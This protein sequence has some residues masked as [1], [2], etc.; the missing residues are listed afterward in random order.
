M[1]VF[2]T[3]IAGVFVLEPVKFTDPRGFFLE[4]F[5]R[6]IWLDCGL[7]DI[8]FVQDNHSSS[9]KGVLRGLHFQ[10]PM[11][12]GKLIRVISGSIFDAVVDTRK[13]SPTFGQSFTITLSGDHKRQ[14]WVAPGVAHGFLALEAKT[15]FLFKCTDYYAPEF[16]NCLLWSDP[17]LNIE[18][19]QLDVEI[20]LSDKD[21]QGKLIADIVNF[22]NFD[23][24]KY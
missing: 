14:L 11:P 16:D 24:I 10:N 18:W 22:P 21:A 9:A 8:E 7:P 4:T 13:G 17:A 2:P 3:D 12:Q 6:K 19:P 20:V 1:K 15:E 23:S 5:N